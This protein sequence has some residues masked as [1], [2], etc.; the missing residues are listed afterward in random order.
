MCRSSGNRSR[1]AAVVLGGACTFVA[2]V[3]TGVPPVSASAPVR[4]AQA[5]DFNGDGYADLAAGVQGEDIGSK[6]NAGAVNVIYG[7]TAGPTATGDQFWSQDS[8]GV[9]GVAEGDDAFREPESGDFNGDGYADLAVGVVGEKIGALHEAGAVNIFYGSAAGLTATGSRF[10]S[11]DSSGVPGVAEEIDEF[12][13]TLAAGDFNGDARDDLVIGS[14]GEDIGANTNNS[15]SVTV[16]YGAAT[17]LG[18]SVVQAWSSESLGFAYGGLFGSGLAAG[19]V[20][21][22]GRDDLVVVGARELYVVRGGSAGLSAAAAQHLRNVDSVDGSMALADFDG[23]HHAD[24][25]LGNSRYDLHDSGDNDEC[26]IEFLCDGA[27]RV[28]RGGANGFTTSGQQLWHAEVRGVPSLRAT[29]SAVRSQRGISPVT[30]SPSWLC[31]RG[32]L[33]SVGARRSCSTGR[34]GQG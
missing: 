31:R 32:R 10:L 14:P 2:V 22:D 29:P 26:R 13:A 7:S 15:G 4:P 24:V 30:A 18:N 28:L 5:F 25:A 6:T 23:D 34:L 33:T 9:P 11:Q 19:D 17:G 8:D 16:L 1:R 3:T 27:V 12:G 21:G 20:T